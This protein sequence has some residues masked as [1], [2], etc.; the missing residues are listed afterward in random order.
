MCSAKL[1]NTVFAGLWFYM[2][3]ISPSILEVSRQYKEIL[4]RRQK[5]ATDNCVL[6]KTAF[7]AFKHH[8]FI[9]KPYSTARNEKRLRKRNR[10]QMQ[11]L[12]MPN[13]EKDPIL[14][15]C[16]KPLKWE[17]NIGLLTVL[18][19]KS[20]GGC[21]IC[22][23]RAHYKTPLTGCIQGFQQVLTSHWEDGWKLFAVS[24]TY[25]LLAGEIRKESNLNNVLNV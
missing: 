4:T 24:F 10:E 13:C 25:L 3:L 6:S 19:S 17:I 18:S 22:I 1:Q 8:P 7:K 16:G 21:S 23:N 15:F 12:R 2:D 9:T 11:V 20:L 14:L 5:L